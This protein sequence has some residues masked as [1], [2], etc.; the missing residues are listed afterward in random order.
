M[1]TTWKIDPAHSTIGFSA[2]HM[3]ITRVRGRFTDVEGVIRM[4][5]D[6]PASSS[7]E[8]D[9]D[10]ASIDTDVEDRDAHLRSEDFLDVEKH[11]RITFR[12]SRVA[13]ATDEP[14]SEFRVVG[15]LTIAGTTRE[16]TLDA[17]FEGEGRDPWGGTRTA[18]SATT[19]IDRR[20]F[21]LTWNQALETGGILVGHDVTIDLQVQAV[22]EQEA[23]VEAEADAGDRE[24]VGA[25][26]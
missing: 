11:P 24:A 25:G 26:A 2:R 3:M 15:D 5:A 17:T 9:I 7:V 23:G 18:F 19:E 8:V 13:G 6:D 22:K 14:G 12:S 4:D 10:A 20:D 1:S 21:G 16:V